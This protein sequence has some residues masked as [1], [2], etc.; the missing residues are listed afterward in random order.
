[1]QEK[2]LWEVQ[3]D[4]SGIE[5]D[6][7]SKHIFEVAFELG[8]QL[9]NS[10]PPMSI[11]PVSIFKPVVEANTQLKELICMQ[12]RISMERCSQMLDQF[13]KEQIAVQRTYK[14]VADV[15]NHCRNWFK[16]QLSKGNNLPPEKRVNKL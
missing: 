8:Y 12:N 15:N 16:S 4:A 14:D 2:K 13:F 10:M 3:F 5:N 9:G 1:M 11:K 7:Y 6:L